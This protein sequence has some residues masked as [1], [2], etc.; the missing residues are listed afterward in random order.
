MKRGISDNM[1]MWLL[2]G[3]ILLV[4]GIFFALFSW[5]FINH[6]WWIILVVAGVITLIVI[7]DWI[8]Q[9]RNGRFVQVI[10]KVLSIPLIIVY[11]FIGLMQPFIII[12]G[13]Y[14]LLALYAIG[15]PYLL[16]WVCSK[17]GW[18]ELRLETIVFISFAFGAIICSTFSDITKWIIHNSPIKNRG[19]HK[20]EVYREQLAVYLTHP[21]NV[22]FLM[23]LIYFV[24]IGISGCLQIQNDSYLFSAELDAA[25]FKAFLL[26]IAFNN[27]RTK[28]KETNVDVKELYKRTLSLF[29]HD[30]E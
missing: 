8:G 18:I 20:Y 22:V 4:G 24:Y 29:T 5:L 6:E 27:V 28:A 16:L 10:N 17:T 12:V 1:K 2:I 30:D 26:F 11:L 23:Y 15:L 25:V 7:M 3:L 19:E 9:K 14:F 13:C 21:K